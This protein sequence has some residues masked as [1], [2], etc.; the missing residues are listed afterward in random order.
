RHYTTDVGAA[1]PV[2]NTDYIHNCQDPGNPHFPP[3]DDVRFPYRKI[4][5]TPGVSGPA[6]ADDWRAPVAG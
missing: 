1:A 5:W 6:G 3:L 4:P 2:D